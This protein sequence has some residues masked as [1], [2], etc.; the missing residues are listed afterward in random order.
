MGEARQMRLM[1][2]CDIPISRAIMR[3]L[4]CVASLGVDSKV[5]VITA[6]ICASL[7]LRGLPLRGASSSPSRRIA[8]KRA[9]HFD[10]VCGVTGML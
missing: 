1:A 8:T 3:V 5:R 4:Q 9:R 7:I 6:S 2:D 10:T